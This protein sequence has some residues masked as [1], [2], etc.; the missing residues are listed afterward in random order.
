MA[1]LQP[2]L[3]ALPEALE[4]SGLNIFC[5]SILKLAGR[6]Y[7]SFGKCRYSFG[8]QN[9]LRHLRDSFI[10]SVNPVAVRISA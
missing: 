8:A 2:A 5:F 4:Q 3:S 7:T 1:D 6:D 10:T 9:A